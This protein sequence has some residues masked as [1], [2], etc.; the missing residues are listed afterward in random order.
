MWI[1]KIKAKK[2]SK[3][4]NHNEINVRMEELEFGGITHR[5]DVAQMIIE[6]H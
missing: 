4:N 3:V 1:D 5:L 6:H 2:M